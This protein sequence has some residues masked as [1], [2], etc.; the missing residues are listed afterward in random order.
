VNI[1]EFFP[2]AYLLEDPQSREFVDFERDFERTKNA[3][4]KGVQLENDPLHVDV[5]DTDIVSN[6]TRTLPPLQSID[7]DQSILYNFA[8]SSLVN[9]FG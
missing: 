6:S 5:V 2:R 4:L 7:G 1:H 8:L 3:Y 9:I